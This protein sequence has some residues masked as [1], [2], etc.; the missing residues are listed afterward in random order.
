MMRFSQATKATQQ[1]VSQLERT[2]Y[3]VA[4]SQV[5]MVEFKTGRSGRQSTGRMLDL[6]AVVAADACWS[7]GL[8][9]LAVQ[10]APQGSGGRD[11]R[12]FHGLCCMLII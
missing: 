3:A 1:T 6:D 12:Q 8:S 7:A 5:K 11:R 2:E 9:N 4:R 10:S